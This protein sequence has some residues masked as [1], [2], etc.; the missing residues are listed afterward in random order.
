MAEFEDRSGFQD[1]VIPLDDI[2]DSSL[3][4]DGAYTVRVALVVEGQTKQAGKL[5]YS[6]TLRIE[7]GPYDNMPLFDNFVI[8]SDDDPDAQE[9]DTWKRFGAVR[10]KQFVKATG[11]QMNSSRNALFDAL[12]NQRLVVTVETKDSDRGP[13]NRIARYLAVGEQ[14]A[15]SKAHR[16]QSRAQHAGNSQ[17]KF[18]DQYE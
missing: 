2:P 1:R 14:E 8:G 17:R 15:P 9:N 12:S 18:S 11:V 16:P 4:P 10:F 7:G 3:V 6:A 13:Q 5:M